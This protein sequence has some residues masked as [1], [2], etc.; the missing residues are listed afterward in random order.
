MPQKSEYEVENM[1]KLKCDEQ[2]IYPKTK[3]NSGS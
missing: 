2:K 1:N 3:R